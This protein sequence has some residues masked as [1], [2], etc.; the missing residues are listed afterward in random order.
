MYCRKEATQLVHDWMKEKS[1]KDFAEELFKVLNNKEY[2]EL[3]N[4]MNNMV[5]ESI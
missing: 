3:A 4:T 2:K 5:R 1:L